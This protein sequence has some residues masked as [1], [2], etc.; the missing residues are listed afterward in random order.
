MPNY[1]PEQIQ[2]KTELAQRVAE[3]H[4][5]R[6]L[7]K[8]EFKPAGKTN[9]VF[10]VKAGKENFIIR[11]ATSR[12][13]IQDFIKE[14]WATHKAAEKGVPVPEILEVG[15]KVIPFPYM[16]Q[17]KVDGEEAINHPSRHDTVK[18]LGHYARLIHSIPTSE[19][20][21]YFDWSGNKLS[22]NKNWQ[23]YLESELEI[24]DRLSFLQKL[25]FLS[26]KKFERLVS[27]CEKIKK[28]KLPPSLNHGDL[29]LK[30][31]IVNKEG[32]IQA[33]I[34]WDYC[35]SSVAPYWDLSIALH[36]LSIDGKQKF[37][38]GYELDLSEFNRRSYS[39]AVFNFL[40]YIPAL[41]DV[42]KS[43]NKTL[44]EFYKIRLNGG[45]DLFSL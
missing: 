30:N 29:R 21:N 36:D 3:H 22:K 8:I 42:I 12:A 11:I 10:A 31:V 39:I 38:E 7:G 34:D 27:F 26:R 14:Q 25:N 32:K 33:I 43:K 2:A 5:G 6:S 35:I 16:V 15:N 37:L 44:L 17:R 24:D 19:F 45:F 23:E 41:E 28:W 13:K 9:F 18:A 1:S 4:F 20:G 40:N